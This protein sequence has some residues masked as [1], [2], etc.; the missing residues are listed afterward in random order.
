M[1]MIY[2]MM[3]LCTVCVKCCCLHLS[4]CHARKKKQMNVNRIENKRKNLECMKWHSNF[5]WFIAIPPCCC[6]HKKLTIFACFWLSSSSSSALCPYLCFFSLF[7]HIGLHECHLII[8]VLRSC[9]RTFTQ[10]FLLFFSIRISCS[11]MCCASVS[12]LLLRISYRSFLVTCLIVRSLCVIFILYKSVWT[13]R[14]CYSFWE[15]E[16]GNLRVD[17]CLDRPI[18][19]NVFYAHLI[20][21]TACCRWY[22]F[23]CLRVINRF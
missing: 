22:Y 9:R 10:L 1:P 12:F 14:F 2:T 13:I 19:R 20:Q 11:A 21:S 16:R 8:F 7:S 17:V 23:V 6:I 15:G 5:E 3:L 18:I 4:F